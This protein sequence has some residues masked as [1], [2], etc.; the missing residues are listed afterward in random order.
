MGRRGSRCRGNVGNHKSAA[1]PT[2]RVLQKSGELGVT[3]GNMVLVVAAQGV[4]AVGQRQKGAIN[5][6]AL[7]EPL[8]CILGGPLRP[9][10]INQ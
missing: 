4:D 6:G 5:V 1:V 3:V 8:T 7:D 9:G 2:K 10:E